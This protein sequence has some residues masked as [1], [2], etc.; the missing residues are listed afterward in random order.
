MNKHIINS[1][2]APAPIGPYSQAVA[3]NGL[4]F[5]SGQ[6]AL[7][8]EGTLHI[9]D[10]PTETDQVMRNLQAILKE[11]GIDFNAVLKTTIFLTTMDHFSEVNAVYG[12]YFTDA[13]PARETVAVRGLPKGVNVEI[14]MIAALNN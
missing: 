10:I 4:L 2:N 5:I 12:K 9:G 6:I 11:A 13:P 1:N 3:A 8:A 7:D 14:S